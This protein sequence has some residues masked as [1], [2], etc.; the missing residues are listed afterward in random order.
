M[1]LILVFW[2]R[3]FEFHTKQH[4]L[5]LATSEVFSEELS[6]EAFVLKLTK[7]VKKY[8]F[9]KGDLRFKPIGARDRIELQNFTT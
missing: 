9:R 1:Q 4:L 2:H 3:F 5:S 7:I 8:Y 6:L